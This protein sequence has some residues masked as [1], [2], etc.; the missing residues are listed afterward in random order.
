MNKLIDEH[1]KLI[2]AEIPLH[3]ERWLGT[4]S[5]YGDAMPSVDYWY[6]QVEAL[7]IAAAGRVILDDLTNYGLIRPNL[8]LNVVLKKPVYYNR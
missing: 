6:N 4:T 1:Q 7:N 8:S 3:V 2:E 5:S